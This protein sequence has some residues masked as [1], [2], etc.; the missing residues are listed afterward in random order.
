[1][2]NIYANRY[3]T[4]SGWGTAGLIESTALDAR[5]ASCYIAFDPLGNA[6]AVWRHNGGSIDHIR[7]NRFVFE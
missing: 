2:N 3:I 6:L 7:A 4:G 5:D 1:M